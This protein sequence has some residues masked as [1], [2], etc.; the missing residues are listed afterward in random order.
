VFVSTLDW[1]EGRKKTAWF[2]LNFSWGLG[3]QRERCP[4]SGAESQENGG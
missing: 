3:A 1:G 2:S 4:L